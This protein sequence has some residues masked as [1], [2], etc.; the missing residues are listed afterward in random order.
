MKN[1]KNIDPTQLK[2]LIDLWSDIHAPIV[3]SYQANVADE[4]SFM[5]F[6]TALEC[7]ISFQGNINTGSNRIVKYAEGLLQQSVE[8]IAN[9]YNEDLWKK[10]VDYFTQHIHDKNNIRMHYVFHL[11]NIL[12]VSSEERRNI[13][14]DLLAT[15]YKK[16][17][18]ENTSNSNQYTKTLF[19]IMEEYELIN[20]YYKLFQPVTFDNDLNIK[21]ITTFIDNNEIKAAEQHCQ[22]QIQSNYREEYNVPYLEL[23]KEIYT[24]ENDEVNLSKVLSQLF[25]YTYNFDDF[26]YIYDRMQDVEEKKK[27]RTKILSRARTA[28]GNYNKAATEFTFQ[29]MDHEKKYLK[30]ID[31][32]DSGTPYHLIPQYLW[33]LPIKQGY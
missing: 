9:L 26:L 17:F 7:C 16:R 11:K 8:P 32:I 30:M 22:K 12:R 14:I 2:K 19:E 20:K 24:L 18:S 27:W 13:L 21:L 3:K 25:P 23:L 31:Y 5:N 15:L 33:S 10:A 29:L 6:H 4:N 1:K 28:S